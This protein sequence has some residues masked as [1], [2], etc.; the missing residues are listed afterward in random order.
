MTYSNGDRFEGTWEN[1]Q[2][3]GIGKFYI[4]KD[5]IL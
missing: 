5:I 3:Y 1:G 2:K 4:L